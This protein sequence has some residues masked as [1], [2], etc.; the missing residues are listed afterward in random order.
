[1]V[2]MLFILICSC[3][4]QETKSLPSLPQVTTDISY[5]QAAEINLKN[6]KCIPSD[7]PYTKKGLS[8]TEFC[9]EVERR[10][11]FINPKCL[12]EMKDCNQE[13]NCLNPD[14][15]VK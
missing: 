1:M 2:S 8:F 5:C 13:T 6:L 12:S 11:V 9:I 7:I 15:G 10:G 14:G 4:N 3:C